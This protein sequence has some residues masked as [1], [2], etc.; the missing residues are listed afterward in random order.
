M[1]QRPAAEF[2]LTV[3]TLYVCYRAPLPPRPG[4][5]PGQRAARWRRSPARPLN[6]DSIETVQAFRRP[7]TATR[8]VDFMT[9]VMNRLGRQRSARRLRHCSTPLSPTLT[10]VRASK[11]PTSRSASTRAPSTRILIRT[12]PTA[13]RSGSARWSRVHLR[14]S[15][16]VSAPSRRS[17]T[18][19]A[20]P[21]NLPELPHLRLGG[22]HAAGR[23][24][25]HD[26]APRDAGARSTCCSSAK[27]MLSAPR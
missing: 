14:R 23:V 20:V 4:G 7:P 24:R 3:T 19:A 12:E 17:R 18:S 9:G 2:R 16:R 5:A 8:R 27:Q 21:R 25:A 10:T 6:L 11:A 15:L 26:P 22:S 1:L 13:A